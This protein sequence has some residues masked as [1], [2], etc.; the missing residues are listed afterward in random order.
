M[1]FNWRQKEIAEL[2][3][4]LSEPSFLTLQPHD[5]AISTYRRL[6]DLTVVSAED[7]IRLSRI[8]R[9]VLM[10]RYDKSHSIVDVD[11]AV[12]L[13]R[14]VCPEHLLPS[15]AI[16][17]DTI[18]EL[19]TLARLLHARFII[20][21]EQKDIDEGIEIMQC[22]LTSH[23]RTDAYQF[24]RLYNLS[25]YLYA[26]FRLCNDEKDLLEAISASEAAISDMSL[27]S[28]TSKVECLHQLSVQLV[29]LF[30][31]TKEMGYRARAEELNA[32]ALTLCKDN[33]HRLVALLSNSANIAFTGFCHTNF[34]RDMDE[35]R[36]RSKE[37][38]T[39]PSVDWV[40]DL[41]RLHNLA[42]VLL[43]TYNASK[44]AGDLQKARE[45]ASRAWRLAKPMKIFRRYTNATLTECLQ[46]ELLR[47]GT[48]ISLRNVIDA[49]GD[50]IDDLPQ[51]NE[52]AMK[53]DQYEKFLVLKYRNTGDH[54]DLIFVLYQIL[55]RLRASSVTATEEAEPSSL[56]RQTDSLTY[57]F[58]ELYRKLLEPEFVDVRNAMITSIH[59]GYL[60]YECSNFLGSIT[61]FRK[62]TLSRDQ[63]RNAILGIK[64]SKDKKPDGKEFQRRS[65]ALYKESLQKDGQRD[66]LTIL[67]E[68]IDMSDKA[69]DCFPN[70]SSEL[71]SAL[72]LNLQIRSE[73]DL[74]TGTSESNDETHQKLEDAVGK[75]A[76]SSKEW[77]YFKMMLCQ[78]TRARF[79]KRKDPKDLHKACGL[80]LEIEPEIDRFDPKQ[81]SQVERAVLV[82][83]VMKSKYQ[84][85]GDAEALDKGIK[86]MRQAVKDIHHA[87]NLRDKST[88]PGGLGMMLRL[89][90]RRTGQLEDIKQAA[91]FGDMAIQQ[92]DHDTS[93]DNRVIDK[94]RNNVALIY[95]DLYAR[96]KKKEHIDTAI[97]LIE[98]ITIETEKINLANALLLRY[99]VERDVEDLDRAVSLAE[100]AVLEDQQNTLDFGFYCRP[101]DASEIL[102]AKYE[103]SQDMKY[104]DSAI[105]YAEQAI[106]LTEDGNYWVTELSLDLGRMLFMRLRIPGSDRNGLLERCVQACFKAW[107]NDKGPPV[108]RLQAAHLAARVY[109]DGEKW[110]DAAELLSSAVEFVTKVTPPWLDHKDKQHLLRFFSGFAA[111]CA[112][113][114]LQADKGA[115]RALQL[116]ELCR[117][118]V[119]GFTI[120]C[121]RDVSHLGT[122][123]PDLERRFNELRMQL[124]YATTS[125]PSASFRSLQND[126]DYSMRHST[127]VLS[128]SAE[129]QVYDRSGLQQ[130]E[131]EMT[132]LL[133]TIREQ[134]G[135]ED[136]L[137]PPSLR[138]T[139]QLAASGPIVFVFC[140]NT[141]NGGS[142]IIIQSTGIDALPLPELTS[143]SALLHLGTLSNKIYSGTLR[144]FSARNKR[145]QETLLWLWTAVVHPIL[146][147][148]KANNDENRPSST[149]M[150]HIRWIGVGILSGAPFH[151]AGDHSPGCS[152]NTVSQAIS[153]YSASLRSLDYVTETKSR[154][155]H[156]Q[157]SVL[158]ATMDETPGATPLMN[159]IEEA[160]KIISVARTNGISATRIDRPNP[161][162]VL[163]QLPH[164][165]VVHFACHAMSN[166]EEPFESHLLLCE[167][168]RNR[169]SMAATLSVTDLLNN[170]SPK[171][172][173]AYISAC[174]S[175]ATSVLTL[176]DENIHI[177]SGFQLAGFK[178]VIASLW[179]QRDDVCLRIADHFYR[180]FFRLKRDSVGAE[181]NPWPVAQAL[182]EAICVVRAERP[183]KPLLWA[184]FI[185][186]GGS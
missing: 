3:A 141:V 9:E 69:V 63:I 21:A 53:E 171:A 186:I 41:K 65:A 81:T 76:S 148:I 97:R 58:V 131:A 98:Q 90:F 94:H 38:I 165:N 149:N 14:S 42:V 162:Q 159:V 175:A 101:Y 132:S 107:T 130:I 179:Q 137:R 33:D 181:V 2:K 153:S 115:Y 27:E 43:I 60:E 114:S 125:S 68:A 36:A 89:R 84:Y 167:T 85:L 110:N 52:R 88:V 31:R 74:I 82:A 113:A 62:E 116:L 155:H 185:H 160:E 102:L 34:W 19:E 95:Q 117:G 147:H 67:N 109:M 164:H 5:D 64:F 25:R 118:V 105:M 37:A 112:T 174:S 12:A 146:C 170:R 150:P 100:E 124:D 126:R 77:L 178:N 7:R 87:E 120:D 54:I 30:E 144:T 182:H 177:A 134:A 11:E 152:E 129:D 172:D 135:F 104:L 106:K 139:L 108:F 35:A 56:L 145:F 91:T 57:L 79:L 23:M 156:R 127:P 72:L 92:M 151:A 140:S 119:M 6:L 49:L 99:R 55:Q 1:D 8:L 73:K 71:A 166:Y 80:A 28:Q 121:R 26:R 111:D 15:D 47:T 183:D 40:T 158:I 128:R 86:L 157:D 83:N 180:E 103:H 169:K 138:R 20:T 136:F 122:L 44:Q 51:G 66:A 39:H 154:P 59:N 48:S 143:T 96:T 133:T 24:W 75:V 13:T 142:S 32:K 46:A 22:V 123:N 4:C 17:G 184:S 10:R 173:L 168:D 70:G 163:E 50:E 161:G 18:T 45:Y 93:S 16:L 176:A 29:S 78:L 61:H